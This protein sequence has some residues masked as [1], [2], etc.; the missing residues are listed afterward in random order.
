M[1]GRGVAL[2]ILWAVTA[3]P[4]WD[5]ADWLCYGSSRT[6]VQ[7][8]RDVMFGAAGRARLVGFVDDLSNG[9]LHPDEDLPVIAFEEIAGFGGAA[10]FVALHSP[11]GREAVFDRLHAAGVPIVGIRSPDHLAHPRSEYG[12]GVVV[13]SNTRIGP[14]SRLGRGVLATGDLVAHD[15]DVGE[16]TTCAAGSLIA[17]HVR[18]GRR[19]WIGLGATV[20]NGT[21][22][23]PIEIGDDAVIGA[24]AVV[25]R[26]VP[27]GAVVVGNPARALRPAPR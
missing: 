10:V 16:F 8:A 1:P 18:I 9:H 12:E 4:G 2:A 7:V 25:V 19:V 24:G 11:T 21:S 6:C 22:R 14:G 20:S 15:V 26:D 13:A 23:R 5:A 3:I 17:G 27:A